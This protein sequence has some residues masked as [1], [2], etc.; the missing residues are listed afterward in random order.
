MTRKN[1][2]RLQFV[3]MG[4]VVIAAILLILRV[5]GVIG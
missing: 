3:V 1:K 2:R 5:T 4:F